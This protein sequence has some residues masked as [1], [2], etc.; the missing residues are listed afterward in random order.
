MK[1]FVLG[2]AG[3]LVVAQFVVYLAA[4]ITHAKSGA[5]G[6][7][8]DVL[9]FTVTV[10]PFMYFFSIRPLRSFLRSR[11]ELESRLEQAR[12]NLEKQV[13]ERTS[14]LASANEALEQEVQKHRQTERELE[15]RTVAMET[16]ANGILITNQLGE[17]EWANPAFCQMTG[18][19]PDD[20]LGRTPRLLKS[21]E[22]SESFYAG[23]WQTINS[24]KV[25]RGELINRRKDGS[26]YNEEQTITPVRDTAGEIRH[27]I[28][29]KQD[30]SARKEA[31]KVQQAE[32][33]RLFNLLDKL[34]A[35]VYLKDEHYNVRFYN[36]RFLDQFG[37]PGELKCFQIIR[38]L[39]TPCENCPPFSAIDQSAIL[40]WEWTTANGRTYQLT[41]YP[42]VDTGGERMMLQLGIDITE[43]KEAERRLE[44]T[45]AELRKLGATEH[46][47]RRL[48]ESLL[49]AAR[50][51][52]HS[53]DPHAVQETLLETLHKLVPFECGFSLL[54][55]LD[56]G[57][58]LH[59]YQDCDCAR[60]QTWLAELTKDPHQAGL[61]GRLV[62]DPLSLL[63]VD[64]RATPDWFPLPGMEEARAW[65]S[66]PI[67]V[68]QENLGLL[69]LA[70]SRPGVF[71]AKHLERAE[72]ITALAAV[73]LKNALVYDQ[74]SQARLRH[75]SLSR[76]LVRVQEHERRV[77]SRELHDQAGQ[78][79]TSLMVGLGI[80]EKNIGQ[81][82]LVLDEISNMKQIVNEVMEDLHR[83]AMDLRP[84]VLD[85]V[86]LE[87]ALRQHLRGLANRTGLEVAVEVL[88]LADRLSYELETA[89]FRI[90][91][92]AM[93]NVV[94]HAH[95]RHVDVLLKR[96][97]DRLI[98]LIEDDGVGFDPAQVDP[99]EHL[100]LFG[101]RERVEMLGGQLSVESSP[102]MGTTLR[103][104][105]GLDH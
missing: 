5:A 13:E 97:Q 63:L 73:S 40:E 82:D 32:R 35:L 20:L 15:L 18:Y 91:Q 16:A 42:F 88:D 46:E 66:V 81:P 23:L 17:I 87:A 70:H 3:S 44:E 104:E 80:L 72:A 4:T 47:Q 54:R 90:V 41:D 58:S 31:E 36:R 52:S 78:A 98:L 83:L 1:R 9:V 71:T 67:Q 60:D 33:Q 53:L 48:A 77:V 34:P 43:R 102:S 103:V 19:T 59:A 26:L 50:Q 29:I 92:E 69:V 89:L 24:G 8:E 76:R 61:V 12:L 11:K 56:D 75:Q 100:G 101:I 85:H 25:W 27:F 84:A 28:A 62:S 64:V 38:G 105:V 2:L 49:K 14:D 86:G 94:R 45:V 30:I 55:N 93:N 21:G 96:S 6:E 99:A 39:E 68:N 7:W 10:L 22:Q 79:L 51:L 65:I 37:E 57:F 74:V 95:A